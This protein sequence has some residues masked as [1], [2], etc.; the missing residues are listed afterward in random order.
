M[1]PRPPTLREKR[2]YLLV[3]IAP[4]S[5]VVEPREL[6]LAILEALSSLHGDTTVAKVQMAVVKATGEY[7]I[8]RCTRGWEALVTG[9]MSTVTAVNGN[10]VALRTL[11][12]S[13]TILALQKRMA[14]SGGGG[15]E[16]T[17][18]LM[19]REKWYQA[20]YYSGEKV[21]L[22]EKGFK[23]QELLFLTTED[24]EEL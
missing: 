2:R 10:R 11:A 9:A 5:N 23:S 15:P 16:R 17:C 24:L 6:Y 19:Y 4:P 22:I 8:V 7:A 21:D 3:R 12:V 14:G 18:D 13:G 20:Y 1:K